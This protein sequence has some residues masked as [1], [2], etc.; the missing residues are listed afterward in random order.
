MLPENKKVKKLTGTEIYFKCDYGSK[1]TSAPVILTPIRTKTSIGTSHLGDVFVTPQGSRTR[2][3]E[4]S[5]DLKSNPP[6]VVSNNMRPDRNQ[7]CRSSGPFSSSIIALLDM[8]RLCQKRRM[9]TSQ[10]NLYQESYRVGSNNWRKCV[11]PIEKIAGVW[12]EDAI[13]QNS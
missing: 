4:I 7:G 12:R 1:K 2:I 8:W 3:P 13:F 9:V 11:V 5:K 6:P 10:R